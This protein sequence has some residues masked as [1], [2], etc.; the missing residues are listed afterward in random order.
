MDKKL[1]NDIAMFLLDA[2]SIPQGIPDHTRAAAMA[3]RRLK[4]TLDNPRKHQD[5][6][7]KVRDRQTAASVYT[8]KTKTRWPF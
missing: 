3:T 7:N 6:A 8:A 2:G 1:R 4:T 5:L